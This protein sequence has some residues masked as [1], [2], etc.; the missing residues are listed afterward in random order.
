MEFFDNVN[1]DELKLNQGSSQRIIMVAANF[2]KE[3]TSTVLWLMNYKLRIQCIKVTPYSLN[4]NLILDV[5]QI[6]LIKDVE[7]YA[8]S[9]AEKAQ[10]DI[11]I[12][13]TG[14]YKYNLRIEFWKKFLEL[15]KEKSDLL[16]NITHSKDSWIVIGNGISSGSYNFVIAKEYAKVEVYFSRKNKEENK[17]IFDE[18]MK[19][20][21]YIERKFGDKLI[22]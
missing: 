20:K 21:D 18:L 19:K 3:V 11:N 4:D 22:W 5:E 15:F 9:M 13:E 10:D 1:F 12:K 14:K 6:I 7:E 8:I 2:R 16:I 17:F